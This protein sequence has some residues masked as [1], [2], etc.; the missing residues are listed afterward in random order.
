MSVPKPAKTKT[1]L[2]VSFG[3]RVNAAETNQLA[4]I[5]LDQK[6]I[7]WSAGQ[8]TPTVVIV[9]T[10]AVTQKAKRQ[11]LQK[12]RSLQRQYPNATFMLTGCAN[13]QHFTHL[14]NTTV[15]TNPQKHHQLQTHQSYTPDI[16]D[17]F[18]RSHK[19]LLRIQSGCNHFCS[20]CIVPYRRADVWSLPIPDAVLLTQKAQALGYREL[21]LTGIN[22]DLYQPTLPKL[23]EALLSQTTIPLIS[24]GSLPPNSL[25]PK[26][27][28]LFATYPTRLK[29]FFHIPLQS[30]SNSL[31][32]RMNRPYNRAK[33]LSIIQSIK[34]NLSDPFIGVDIIVGFPGE[35]NLDFQE[36][37][38]LLKQVTPDKVHIF[39]FSP[40]P[41]TRAF[42]LHQQESVPPQ[43][44][45]DRI[46]TLNHLS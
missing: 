36:T 1:F 13:L 40:R 4:Q 37:V 17:K 20:Y 25:T 42:L 12:I 29:P 6:Y 11:S 15:I 28:K 2:T 7:P 16:K 34:A 41:G 14:P 44:V 5:M 33:I 38:T 39:P 10:C 46:Q 30:G 35:S 19:Y 9:N 18:S 32:N 45:K 23:L 3:C 21:I 24:F 31:L 22:L 26:L 43:T 27:I 8:G